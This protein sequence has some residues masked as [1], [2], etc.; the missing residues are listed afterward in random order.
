MSDHPDTVPA[1][2]LA[3]GELTPGLPLL[4]EG[5]RSLV[6]PALVLFVRVDEAGSAVAAGHSDVPEVPELAVVALGKR[7]RA[8]SAGS[9]SPVGYEDFTIAPGC[10]LLVAGA[11]TPSGGRA[12]AVAVV[13]H[14]DGATGWSDGDIALIQNVARLCGA[15]IDNGGTE[16]STPSQRRLDDLVTRVAVELMPVTAASLNDALER[17]LRALVDFFAVDASYLRRNDFDRGMS[18]LVAEWPARPDVPDPDPLGEVAFDADPVFAATREL[19]E[20]FVMRPASSPDAYQERVQQA[21]GIDQ[22]SM[23]MVPLVGDR[24]TIGVLGFVK[25]GDRPWET[26]ETNAL[27]VVASLLVQ[28][29]ARIDA[30]DRLQYHAYHDGLTGLPNRR[31][32]L[33]EIELRLIENPGQATALFLLD[34]DRFKAM[35]NFLGRGAGD[36]LL[37]AIGERLSNAMRPGDFVARLAGDEFVFVLGAP[38]DDDDV[39]A[40]ADSLLELVA[41]PIEISGHHITRTG[42]VGI[43]LGRAGSA[44]AEGLIGQA[45]AALHLAKTA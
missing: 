15:F 28:L 22:V 2:N 40:L 43:A 35:N 44:D 23:A 36:R 18:V 37:V 6:G 4:V 10:Q 34:L 11:S 5:L 33:D 13:R 16:P 7:V 45:H 31:A 19:K 14:R 3:V 29:Y 25:F 30:E 20:P 8:W 1:A 41:G 21:S 12:G 42:S 27:Q 9:S 32:L 39:L 24:T 38:T 26:A 17:T